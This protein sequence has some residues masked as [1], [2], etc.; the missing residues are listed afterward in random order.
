M[1][2]VRLELFAIVVVDLYVIT[3]VVLF[4]EDLSVGVLF[5]LA[6]VDLCAMVVVVLFAVAFKVLV[7]SSEVK[8]VKVLSWTVRL[9]TSPQLRGQHLQYRQ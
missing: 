7:I 2:L 8:D 3:E 1:D 6:E 9:L 4:A 5:A